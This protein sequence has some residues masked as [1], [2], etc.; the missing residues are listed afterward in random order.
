MTQDRIQNLLFVVLCRAATT[1]KIVD[2]IHK[3]LRT[4]IRFSIS[5][6]A[7]SSALERVSRTHV[8]SVLEAWIL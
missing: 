7:I 8:E 1:G 6:P 5:V 2:Q 3:R 4:I